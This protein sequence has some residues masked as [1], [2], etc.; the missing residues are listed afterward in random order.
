[1]VQKRKNLNPTAQIT[2]EIGALVRLM[3]SGV[4][5]N[6]TSHSFVWETDLQPTPLSMKYRIKIEYSYGT[7]PQVFVIYPNPLIKYPS[8]S[9]L[10]H[11]YST[12]EQ[13][14]CLYYPGFREWSKEKLIARTILPWA[15]EWLQYYEL[16]LATGMW[17]GEG[18][19][20]ERNKSE[21][22]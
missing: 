15:S 10:P 12:E 11:T 7:S 19:H 16:W 22:E 13:K 8:E 14:I 1:M 5:T 6:Q 21:K 20:P 9:T 2:A 3:P 18:I 17:L 4:F